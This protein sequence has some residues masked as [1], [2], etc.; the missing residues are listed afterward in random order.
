[1]KILLITQ[2]FY[3]D[4]VSTG[5]HMT[6]LTTKWKEL[7]PDVNISVFTAENSRES[8]SENYKSYECYQGISVFRVRN[9]GKHHGNLYRRFL[10]SIGFIFNAFF[11]LIKNKGKYNRLIITTNP[12]FLGLLVLL[13]NLVNRVPYVVIAYDLYPQILAKMGILSC[14]SYIYKF[15]KWLNIRVYNNSSKIIS[16]GEDMTKI[17]LEDMIIK[18][19]SKIELI[20]NWSDKNKVF[21]V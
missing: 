6:E 18:D 13:L 21:P 4:L 8:E 11:F 2:H 5:L 1:M 16:I 17:I 20:H 14:D 7:Y 9:I 3:P 19:V 12:P 10:F 15:W